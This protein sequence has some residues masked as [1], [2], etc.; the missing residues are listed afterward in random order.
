MFGNAIIIALA[1]TLAAEPPAPGQT[2]SDERICR[3]GG[4]RSL[5]SHIRTRRRC[6]T[7]EQWRQEEEAARTG[8]VNGLQVTAGQNDGQTRATPR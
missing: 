3:G 1:F 8:P 6:L 7:A 5:G 4:Q 2:Q